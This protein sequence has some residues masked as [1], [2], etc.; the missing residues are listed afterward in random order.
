MFVCPPVY[1]A[2]A[3]RQPPPDIYI[4]RITLRKSDAGKSMS[5][6]RGV[7]G[8]S[9]TLAANATTSPNCV[10]KMDSKFELLID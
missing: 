3:T 6:T 5:L 1:V 10:K 8:G 7:L 2:S 9:S 4:H